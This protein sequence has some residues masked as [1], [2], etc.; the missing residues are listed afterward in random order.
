[1]LAART[2]G[3]DSPS[4]SQRKEIGGSPRE[5]PQISRVRIPSA[6]SPWK[7]NGSIVGGTGKS[8]N[9]RVFEYKNY[10]V[11]DRG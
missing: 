5:T 2:C 8:V 6:K 7:K 10:S 9:Y 4:L 11:F 3:N 1:M